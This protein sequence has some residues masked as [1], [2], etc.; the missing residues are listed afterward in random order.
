VTARLQRHPAGLTWIEPAGMARAAHA[1]HADGKVWLVDPFDDD[2]ALTAATQL[3]EVTGVLQLLDRHNR[4]GEAIAGRF[5]VPLA[6]L[7]QRCPDA[8]FEVVPVI[9]KRRWREIALWWPQ[10]GTLIVAEAVG[11]APVFA[12]GRAAGVHPLLRM[13]P[14]RGAL[15]AY[16]PDVLLVGHGS[17]LETDAGQ[18]LADA[19]ARARSDLPRLLTKAPALLRS[20]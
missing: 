19:L 20:S 15:G 11:T 18:A 9:S 12:L 3:G 8:P 17:A 4:D 7:P 5:G 6:R 10:A 2:A 16:R 1:L 13:T 14:P